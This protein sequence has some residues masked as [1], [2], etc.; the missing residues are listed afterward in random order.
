M[1]Y[2]IVVDRSRCE[3]NAVCEKIAPEVFQVGEDDKLR[4]LKAEV[5]SDLLE[6]VRRAVE[7]CPRAALSIEEA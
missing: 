2:R 7:R 3:A 5:G 4:V 1:T 6:K